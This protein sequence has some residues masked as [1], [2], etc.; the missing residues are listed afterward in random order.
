MADPSQVFR[1]TSLNIFEPTNPEHATLDSMVQ[2]AYEVNSTEI[3]WWC[4]KK[5]VAVVAQ[6]SFEKM[7]GEN[8][9]PN[10]G[11]FAGP[12]RV[13]ANNVVNPIIMEVTRLGGQTVKDIDLFCGIAAMATYLKDS[14]GVP[15][16]GDV[17]RITRLG[18][19]P[20]KDREYD[21]YT[22]AH[23]WPVDMYNNRYTSWQIAAEQTDMS[24]VPEKIKN[25]K[26]GL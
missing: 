8:V 10:K 3:M 17:F 12:Y 16:S 13:W 24:N 9:T 14:G 6:S 11:S 26:T 25:F 21:F 23:A 19:D 15:V 20:T 1:P 4:F 18:L 2:E 7:Y 5:T 22:V